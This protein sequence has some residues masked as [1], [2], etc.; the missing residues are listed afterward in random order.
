M[1]W[2]KA[3]GGYIPGFYA[4]LHTFGSDIKFHPHLHIL[5]TAGGLCLDHMKWISA[6]V[7]HLL[8][9]PVETEKASIPDWRERQLLHHGHDRLIC[10][11]CAAEMVLVAVCFGQP[12]HETIERLGFKYN[13]KIP[14]EQFQL[15]ADTG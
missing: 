8:N 6:L 12:E 3:N 1:S 15:I 2:T 14:S 13:D 4:V 11:N 5:I 7:K 9:Q 10:E